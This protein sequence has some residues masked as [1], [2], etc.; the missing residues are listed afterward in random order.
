MKRNGRFTV[1]PKLMPR[2]RSPIRH[3]PICGIAMLASKSRDD[4]AN[5]DRFEC[6]T[7]HTVVSEAQSRSDGGPAN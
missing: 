7:C 4:L 3:C 5:F 1:V 2:P 6:L